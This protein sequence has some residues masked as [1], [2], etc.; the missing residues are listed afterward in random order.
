[1]KKIRKPESKIKM[2]KNGKIRKRKAAPVKAKAAK[3]KSI[4]KNKINR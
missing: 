4:G 1:M 2:F 3:I